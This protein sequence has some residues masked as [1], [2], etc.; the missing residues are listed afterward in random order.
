MENT[1]CTIIYILLICQFPSYLKITTQYIATYN[2]IETRCLKYTDD[3]VL[4]S[5]SKEGLQKCRNNLKSY[6]DKWKLEINTKKT[7]VVSRY[8]ELTTKKQLLTV[9]RKT[10]NLFIPPPP[11][12]ELGRRPITVNILYQA[13]KY[14][15]RLPYLNK[16]RLL[17][18]S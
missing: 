18:K 16:D 3:L 5:T 7:K 10:T 1:F 14:F 13:I 6:C 12:P 9:S 17:Y 11:P 4:M 8:Q 2:I 15:L